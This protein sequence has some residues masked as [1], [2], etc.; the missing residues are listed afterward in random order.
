MLFQ[1]EPENFKPNAEVVGCYC[2]HDGRILMVHRNDSAGTEDAWG[3]P[4][5]H[6]ERGEVLEEALC[7]ELFEELGWRVSAE[8]CAY[9]GKVFVRRD[10]DWI[11]HIY[12]LTLDT[13]PTVTL[14]E[15]NKHYAWVTPQEA[16]GMK[17][18]PHGADCIRMYYP[19]E[20]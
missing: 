12:R 7:R 13:E 6:V 1:E 4:A 19:E 20:M 10:E 16:L 17:L 15:E 2:E 14:N 3:L 8:Q 11:F 9:I 18:V 5:G